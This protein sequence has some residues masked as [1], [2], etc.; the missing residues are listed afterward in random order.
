M[1]LN[2]KVKHYY[3]T[4]GRIHAFVY[5]DEYTLSK[6]L[7]LVKHGYATENDNFFDS[8]EEA[9]QLLLKYNRQ[10]KLKKIL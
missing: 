7:E 3:D 10:Q 4:W 9:E 6:N 2:F 8:I 1:N 5:G